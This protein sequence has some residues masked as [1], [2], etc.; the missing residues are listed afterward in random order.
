MSAAPPPA[1]NPIVIRMYNV[2]FGDCFL[3]FVPGAERTRKI[4]IDCG[5]RPSGGSPRPMHEVVAEVIDSVKEDGV[6]RIDV[7][8]GTHRHRDHVSG[9]D[10]DAWKEVEVGEVWLPWTEHPKDPEARKIRETQGGVARHL[11]VALARA[12]TDEGLRALALNSLPNEAAMRTLH[13]GFSGDP[14]R[15]FLPSRR[16]D[17]CVFALPG[18]PGLVVHALGPSHDPDVIRDMDP[19]VGQSYLRLVGSADPAARQANDPFDERW[20][21]EPAD[22]EGL[23]RNLTLDATDLEN[24]HQLDGDQERAVAVALEKAV[25]GTSLMLMFNLGKAHLLFP[26]DAQWGTWRVVLKDPE[27]RHVLA[28][29]TFYKV[30]HHGSHNANP[31]EFV[32]TILGSDFWAMASTHAVQIWPNIPK[33]ELLKA[34][35]KKTKKVIRSDQASPA[36][37]VGFTRHGDLYIEARIPVA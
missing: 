30:G 22:Y 9:F 20:A 31:T 32:E 37:P 19:P 5:T 3:L 10:Q 15:R 11:N 4:L 33:P 26:G 35:K 34:L 36:S 28:R 8:V 25:N 1:E 13:A 24:I 23:Y 2:G 29:T 16:R 12:G 6:P 17:R 18:I 27:L 14:K 21:L 7:V